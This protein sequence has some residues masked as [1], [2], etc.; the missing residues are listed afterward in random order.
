[1]SRGYV[2]DKDGVNASMLICEMAAYYKAQGKDLITVLDDI[3]KKYGY[4]LCAQKS[5]SC[6]GQTGMA[7]IKGIMDSLKENP[8]KQMCGIDVV[9]VKDYSISLCKNTVDGSESVIN[10]PKAD[11]ISFMLK[12]DSLVIVR[13]SGTEPKIKLYVNAMG[14]TESLANE[15]RTNL[16]AEG[17]KLLG[18]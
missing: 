8:P 7:K 13:P 15:N 1:M 5:F 17:S 2:R 4:C 18:F 14:E 3:Y 10:L 11:V 12:D 9:E 6:E 16:L